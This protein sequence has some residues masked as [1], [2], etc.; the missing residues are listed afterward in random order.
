MSS[1]LK[2]IVTALPFSQSPATNKAMPKINDI[3]ETPNPNAVK[4][5]LREPVTHGVARQFGSADQ[6]QS[7]TL[8]RSLFDVGN[9]VS[10]FYMDNMITVEKEDP[11]DW[12][13]L[14]PTW[15]V[16]IPAAEPVSTTPPAAAGALGGAI[17]A[18]YN[19]DARLL[20]IHQIPDAKAQPAFVG[21]GGYD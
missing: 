11:A 7:D 19:R 17:A 8:A 13:E 21:D 3:Q 6:A 2:R 12:D 14:L 5:I 1:K 10:V 15:A 9:V 20:L 18:A 16:P 4:F